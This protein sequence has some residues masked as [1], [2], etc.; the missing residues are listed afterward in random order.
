MPFINMYSLRGY[1]LTGQNLTTLAKMII[2]M[3]SIVHTP[4]IRFSV[5]V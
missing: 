4:A 2:F 3:A 1:V 5:A